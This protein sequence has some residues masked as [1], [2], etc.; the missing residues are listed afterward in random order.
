MRKL[1]SSLI[2][3]GVV[4][5]GCSS[6]GSTP[7]AGTSAAQSGTAPTSQAVVSGGTVSMAVGADPGNL[8]PWSSPTSVNLTLALFAYDTIV[9]L[10]TDGSIVSGLADTWK[11][12]GLK[13]TFGIR[14][15]VT[16]ADGTVMDAELIADNIN[17]AADPANKSPMG[18]LYIPAKATAKASGA[19]TLVVTLAEPSPFLLEGLYGFPI[20]C[21]AGLDDRASLAKKTQGSG[22][23]VLSEV[24]AGDRL[25][26][27]LRDG[28]TWGAD[29]ATTAEAG[30]PKTVVFR[31]VASQTTIANQILA[32]EVNIG[33]VGGPDAK[34]MEAAKLFHADVLSPAGEIF[35]NQKKGLLLADV[36]LRRALTMA[37]DLDQ[38]NKVYSGG[39]GL[40]P[41]QLQT[42]AVT[43]PTESVA[44]NVPTFDVEAAKALLDKAGWVVGADG[45]RA[46]DG[47]RL[48]LTLA[49][50]TGSTTIAAAAEYAVT[51]WRAVGAEV[52]ASAKN[53]ISDALF[54]TTS[55]DLAW[56]GVGTLT[57]SQLVPFFSGPGP[58]DGNNFSHA[59]NADYTALAAQAMKVS[60]KDGC[61]LW[62]EAEASLLSQVNLVPFSFATEQTWGNGVT[63][64][65]TGAQVRAT[66]LR[67]TG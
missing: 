22:P 14:S 21:R 13:W 58:T 46:R 11:N 24:A 61:A 10:G 62:N 65:I 28:Y 67:Q 19:N 43:C 45:I 25:T 59:E 64:E 48:T 56:Q 53:V 6:G 66:S 3:I 35:F 4:A 50:D 36:D 38:L 5:T 54:G 49:Y 29:G 32:K 17:F 7:T 31:V 40:K 30:L 33:I 26:Y 9:T 34:R 39:T 27:T 20:V 15:G 42:L 12:D 23:Y 16:C 1:V 51:Q 2:L 44:A 18:G 60:G 57:P 55:W 47:K 41:T 37:V 52:T 63:F 8:D